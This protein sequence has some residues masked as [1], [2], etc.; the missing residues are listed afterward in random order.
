MQEP[1]QS[2]NTD[3]LLW[4]ALQVAGPDGLTYAD[5]DDFAGLS[6]DI[7]AKRLPQW[8]PRRV[9]RTGSGRKGD[10]FRWLPRI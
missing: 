2:E 9:T 7:A 5:F 10:P 8:Y 6:R 1:S 4:E 3:D